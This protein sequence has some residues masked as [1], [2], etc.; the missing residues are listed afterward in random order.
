MT[1]ELIEHKQNAFEARLVNGSFVFI[2]KMT[3]KGDN[4]RKPMKQNIHIIYL[5]LFVNNQSSLYEDES[6][7][8][9][10]AFIKFNRR[11][12]NIYPSIILK[13]N[14]FDFQYIQSPNA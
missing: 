13:Y 7:I 2:E 5:N 6:L 8:I 14:L 4:F 12:L 3:K 9:Y 11:L 1:I 10:N